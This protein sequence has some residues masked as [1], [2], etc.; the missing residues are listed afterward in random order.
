MSI[1]KL[2]RVVSILKPIV[3]PRFT[4]MSVE[5]PCRLELP[6][7]LTFQVLSAVPVLVFSHATLLVIGV[8]HGAAATGGGGNNTKIANASVI[9]NTTLNSLRERDSPNARTTAPMPTTHFPLARHV[10]RHCR[11]PLPTPHGHT[12]HR[13]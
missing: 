7:P 11:A 10:V 4:L 3:A 12:V 9:A 8:S 1:E 6:A 5:K 13:V 2:D